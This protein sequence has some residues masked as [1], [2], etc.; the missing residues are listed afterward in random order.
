MIVLKTIAKYLL[1]TFL[2]IQLIMVSYDE[3]KPTDPAKEIKAPP[4]I[5]AIL[6]RSCYDCHSNNPNLPW[7]KHIAPFSWTIA[8]HVDLGKKWVNFSTWEEYSAEEKEKKLEEIYRSVYAAMPLRSYLFAHPEAD[9]SMQDRKII[10]DWTG[11]A[12]F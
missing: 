12:P 11:K 8:R 4:E 2:L 6:Q 3:P 10:R 1:G 9:L 7:Y 5:M